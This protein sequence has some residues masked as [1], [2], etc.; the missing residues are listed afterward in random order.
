[1]KIQF[2]KDTL[3]NPYIGV[4]I[5]PTLP[6][7]NGL[8]LNDILEVGLTEIPYFS[9]RNEYL[10]NRNSNKYHLTVFN[11]AEYGTNK[12]HDDIVGTEVFQQHIEYIGIGSIYKDTNITYFVVVKCQYLN[13][14]RYTYGF[15]D[16]DLHITI[17]FTHKDL[18]NASKAT[19]NIW[20]P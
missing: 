9:D 10:L 1:M 5:N 18:F 13:D 16:K 17:A 8:T 19:P 20:V 4:D 11:V 3:G 15:T 14:I 6:D 12:I 2:I 7:K